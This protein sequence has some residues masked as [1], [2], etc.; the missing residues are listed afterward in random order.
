MGPG[1]ESGQRIDEPIYLQD[2]MPTTL[3]LAGIEPPPSVEFHSLLPLL[4]GGKSPYESIYGGYLEKQRSIRTDQY[5]LIVY[6]EA[7]TMRLY[8]IQQDPKEMI[9]LA[10]EPSRQPV[11]QKL[12]AELQQLQKSMNDELDLSALKP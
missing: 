3:E 10:Q 1:V 9:D 6:P 5:K 7:K 2:V 11:V 4:A 12:F 8:D